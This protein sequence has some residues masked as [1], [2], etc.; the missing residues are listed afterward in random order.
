MHT[1]MELLLKTVTS[2]LDPT[3]RGDDSCVC[4]GDVA[5]FMSEAGSTA[6]NAKQCRFV[7]VQFEWCGRRACGRMPVMQAFTWLHTCACYQ[8]SNSHV[9]TIALHSI[10]QG[11][12]SKRPPA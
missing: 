4:W 2:R 11:E 5:A 6:R 1:D 9:H 3:R 8:V 7:L 10:L 12:V